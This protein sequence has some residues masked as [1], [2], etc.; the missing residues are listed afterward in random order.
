MTER[1]P[2]PAVF[3]GSPPPPVGDGRVDWITRSTRRERTV[4]SAVPPTYAR[5]ATIVIP[6]DD[7]AKTLADAALVEVLTAHAPAQL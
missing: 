1:E 3:A 6:E 5:Y 7:A 4:A 2:V